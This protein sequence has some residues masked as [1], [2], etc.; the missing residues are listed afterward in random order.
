[1]VSFA[2]SDHCL[3]LSHPSD[4]Y[5][6]KKFV[7]RSAIVAAHLGPS[8]S[9]ASVKALPS[10][11]PQR[12]QTAPLGNPTASSARPLTSS[13]TLP[14]IP[15]TATPPS[16][17]QHSLPNRSATQPPSAF[18]QQQQ[19]QQMQQPASGVWSDLAALQGPA[20]NSSLPLQYQ[21]SQPLALPN[22]NPF[23]TAGTTPFGN[24]MGLSPGTN[25][26]GISPHL[27]VGGGM[28]MGPGISSGLNMNNMGT[29]PFQTQPQMQTQAQSASF[30]APNTFSS[31][32]TGAANPFAQMLAAQSH[33]QGQMQMQ[34]PFQSQPFTPQQNP[35]PQP[36][37][38]FLQQQPTSFQ[39]QPTAFAPSPQ[40]FALQ[41]QANPFYTAGQPMLA[42]SQAPFR[43]TPSPYGGMGVGTQFQ[44]Q[45]SQPQQMF[46]AQGMQ[47]QSSV[48][49]QGTNPFTGWMQQAAPAQGGFTGQN[50]PWGSM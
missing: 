34:Q 44:P 26:T 20:Q 19:A 8:R 5:E 48:P 31:A 2:L 50:G 38:T 40:P 10:S 23:P 17:F 13:Q 27:A 42:Q 6:F 15:S 18:Q 36:T 16:T 7:S 46:A 21:T 14:Q 43:T 4:K 29:P 47:Q 22:H 41:S 37:P 3:R 49:V 25:A 35:F 33:A 24:G 28:G 32:G 12:S 45:Q 1:M 39:P 11:S 30:G 9:A